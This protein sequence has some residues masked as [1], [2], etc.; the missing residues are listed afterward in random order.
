M[1][2][3]AVILRALQLY[4]HNAHNL[5]KGATFFEDHEYFG[6]L[7]AAYEGEYDSIVEMMIG[8]EEKV[9]LCAITEKACELACASTPKD[10]DEAFSVI[11]ET[12]KSLKKELESEMEKQDLGAQNLIQQI[13]QNSR[14]R[15]Y[16]IGQ[17]LKS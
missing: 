13:A 8:G 4:A 5:A 10:N 15:C 1:K 12:E 11:Y 3:I 7:Y 9:D 16:K 6:E 14:D 17:R 2:G